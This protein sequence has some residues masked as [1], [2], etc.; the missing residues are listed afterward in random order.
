MEEQMYNTQINSTVMNC[1]YEMN[2]YS[3]INGEFD[4]S[5]FSITADLD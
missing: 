4:E 2:E 1:L 3:Y 5:E